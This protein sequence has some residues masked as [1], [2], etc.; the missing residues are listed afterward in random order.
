MATFRAS[1][2]I[3]MDQFYF[4]IGEVIVADNTT[5]ITDY[6]GWIDTFRGSFQYD[7][8]N[9]VYG[10]LDSITESYGDTTYFS[11]SNINR[12]A[13]TFSLYYDSDDTLGAFAYVFSGADLFEGSASN[14][15]LNGFRGSDT[16]NGNRGNDL[17]SGGSENDRL[18]GGTG[19]DVLEG[20]QGDDALRGGTGKDRLYGGSGGDDFIFRT[21]DEAGKG[22]SRDVIYSF[23][24][25]LDDISLTGIDANALLEGNQAFRFINANSFT[26]AAGQ[27]NY[28]NGILAADVN[29]DAA[30]D[31]Q[32]A[33][34]GS[35]TLVATD[36]L[37]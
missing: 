20:A 26:G 11:I 28:I 33:L 22:S 8:Y 9:Y 6:Y 37:L 5:I 4:G 25:G 31:M 3:D 23:Q 2:T 29:G 21:L 34:A 14:D 32:I 16:I 17:L 10:R 27:V 12:D 35:P 15:V 18:F 13:Y 7:Y 24:G 1:T 19:T 36:L 30:V